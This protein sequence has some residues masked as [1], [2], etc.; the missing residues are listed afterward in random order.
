M[1]NFVNKRDNIEEMDKS[2][3]T[4]INTLLE[5]PSWLSG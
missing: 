3:E 2:L 5:F 1:N 4:H